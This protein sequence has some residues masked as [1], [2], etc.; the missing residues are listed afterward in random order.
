MRRR[1]LAL[2]RWVARCL[3]HLMQFL[4][5]KL[6]RAWVVGLAGAERL[7][8]QLGF[9]QRKAPSLSVALEMMSLTGY[10]SLMA[11]RTV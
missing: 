4:K 7:L 5:Q 3:L 1:A 6:A 11:K 8:L 2:M 10:T 9:H